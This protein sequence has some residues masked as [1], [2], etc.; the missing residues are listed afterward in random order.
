LP[1][2]LIALS[3]RLGYRFRDEGLLLEAV[4]HAS[5][6]RVSSYERLEFLGDRV[7][8]LV[9]ADMLFHHFPQEPEGLLARRHA[10][11][12]SQD[13]LAR[14]AED[15]ELA[16]HLRLSAGEEEGG[17][18]SNPAT[19]ADVCEAL[20]GALYLDGGLTAARALIERLWRPLLEADQ[21]PPQD[22]KTALQEWAQGAGL[23]LP[24]YLDAD[25]SGSDH[26]PLFTV[27]VIVEGE[28]PAEGQGRSK[29]AAAQ[30]AAG[31][32]LERIRAE[33]RIA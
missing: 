30:A 20:L 16:A 28:P 7:L 10:V 5:I 31:A 26:E 11:L 3:Q 23:S 18:R 29:R 21:Q 27:R 17:G 2:D 13:S 25:R 22:N 1:P 8:G 19:L 14:V 6:A 12:V 15:L 4:S 24:H 9:I 32:L 33:G